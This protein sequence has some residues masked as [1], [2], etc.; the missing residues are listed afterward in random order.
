MVTVARKPNP[1]IVELGYAD[2]KDRR[3][4]VDY[5]GGSQHV[6]HIPSDERPPSTN[7]DL[8]TDSE[9]VYFL[10]NRADIREGE[11]GRIDAFVAGIGVSN[12]DSI[13][14]SGHTDSIGSYEH[15]IRLSER[16]ADAVKDHLASMGV[17]ADKITTVGYGEGV[18]AAGNGN[19]I[20]RQKNRR[21]EIEIDKD[22]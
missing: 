5:V 18:P 12:I 17:A 11:K 15:N 7:V 2:I 19:G 9:T 20:G 16:R 22:N 6:L 14:V 8:K 3:G 21:S 13:L 4:T 10:F 1:V